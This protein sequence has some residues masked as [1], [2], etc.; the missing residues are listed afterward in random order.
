MS[1][2]RLIDTLARRGIRISLRGLD[3]LRLQAPT[4]VL[5][6]KLLSEIRARKADI[7][8]ALRPVVQLHPFTCCGRFF[9]QEPAVVCF[10]CRQR[11]PE[12]RLP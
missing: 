12:S 3:G 2:A 8:R 1:A 5:T 6:P 10:W 4:R 7:M 11:P 9:F